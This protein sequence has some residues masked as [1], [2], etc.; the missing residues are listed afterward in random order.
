MNLALLA[1]CFT[2]TVE[3]ALSQSRVLYVDSVKGKDSAQCLNGDIPCQHLEYISTEINDCPNVT[4]VINS[5]TLEVDNTAKF[6]SCNVI[7][8]VS[9]INITANISCMS[10]ECLTSSFHDPYDTKDTF[11]S[12]HQ[13]DKDCVPGYLFPNCT[14]VGL[15]FENI[16]SLNISNVLIDNCGAYSSFEL[17]TMN[18]S[19]AIYVRNS[20]NVALQNVTF[21]RSAG[22]ALALFNTFGNVSVQDVKFQ[23]NIHS[24]HSS[25]VGG[26]L[27][28]FS[29]SSPASYSF[30][31]CDFCNNSAPR[32]EEYLPNLSPKWQDWDTHGLGGAMSILFTNESQNIHVSIRNCTFR[33][34]SAPWGAGLYLHFQDDSV[35]MNKV[36]I[37]DSCFNYNFAYIAGGGA[38][39]GYDK[40]RQVNRVLFKNTTFKSNQARYGGGTSVFSFFSDY[41]SHPNESVLFENCTWENNFAFYSP[42]VD[43]SPDRLDQLNTG[44]LPIP[45]FKDCLFKQNHLCYRANKHGTGFVTSGVFVVSRSTVMFLGNTM[46]VDNNYTALLLN[47]ARGIFNCSSNVSFI[48]NTGIRGAAIAMYGFSVLLI[49]DDV[50]FMFKNNSAREVGGGIYYHSNEQRDFLEGR[51]CFLQYTGSKKQPDVTFVFEDNKANNGGSS[52]F[53]VSFYSCFFRYLGNLSTHNLTDFFKK[54]GN[55]SFYDNNPNNGLA[56]VGINF[57]YNKSSMPIKA[58][59]GYPVFVDLTLEDEFNSIVSTELSLSLTKKST[60]ILLNDHYTS[61]NSITVSGHPQ[62]NG[63]VE[64]STRGSIHK[65][66][67]DVNVTLLQCPP[68]Y[69][70]NYTSKACKC[71]ADCKSQTYQGIIKCSNTALRAYIRHGFWVGYYKPNRIQTDEDSIIGVPKPLYTA[72]C[73]LEFCQLNFINYHFHLMP[74]NSKDLNE[75]VCVDHR[76]GVVCGQC[77]DNYS[78]QYHSR[79]FKCGEESRCH[80]G[81][82]FYIISEVFPMVILFVVVISLNVSFTSGSVTGLILFSQLIDKL[83]IDYK[84]YTDDHKAKFGPL[85]RLRDVY[86]IIYGIFD[87]EFFSIDGLSFCLWKGASVMDVLI[88]KYITTLIALFLVIT[89][90]GIMNTKY[91]LRICNGKKQCTTATVKK[92]IIHGLSAFLIICYAQCTSVTFRILMKVELWGNSKARPSTLSMTYNGGIPY[93]QEEHLI[94]AIPAIV[95]L[96]TIVSIPPM[97]LLFNPLLLNLLALCGLSEHPFVMCILRVFQCHRLMP[98]FDCFQSTFKDNMRF[99]AGLYFLYRVAILAAY[100]FSPRALTFYSTSELFLVLFLGATAIAQPHK[101]RKHNIRDALLILNLVVINGLTMFAISEGTKCNENES[102]HGTSAQ[103]FIFIGSIQIVLVYAPMLYVVCYWVYKRMKQPRNN[104]G[105]NE[106]EDQ[107]L[108]FDSDRSGN[109]GATQN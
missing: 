15:I 83:T 107:E 59:P 35:D 84:Y 8:I 95:V 108:L 88:F 9:G 75:F 13:R 62:D 54:I 46:F 1:L 91:C 23:H 47:S 36:T 52:I 30:E 93:F 92:S 19:A 98:L 61:N 78:V 79:H 32:Y 48:K 22:T 4:I 55:F 50:Y 26:V 80:F 12:H 49:N 76:Q 3:V 85:N 27:V 103:V 38:M 65:V 37:T 73:P 105:E 6:E 60:D 101:L 68:G 70:L 51:S 43:I 90:I 87:F 29:S 72:Y 5:S 42:A 53:S 11:N 66:F 18:L 28:K 106:F 67:Y 57:C 56:T 44:F 82:L 100:T 16:H 94:Y 41:R 58:Y 86:L 17:N 81:I 31:N 89:L 102:I 39:I 34:N 104:R 69:Y 63:T 7:K 99:F 40:F 25:F 20:F 64:V 24:V 71:S 33:N 21:K 45:V 74:N 14:N 77:A 97:L 109:Y 96:M 10:E 2:V